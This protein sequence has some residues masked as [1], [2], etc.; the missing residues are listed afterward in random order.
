MSL[1]LGINSRRNIIIDFIIVNLFGI[2][3]MSFSFKGKGFARKSFRYCV[4]LKYWF[5]NF[6]E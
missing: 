1:K 5:G 6:G 4:Q 2:G 3:L